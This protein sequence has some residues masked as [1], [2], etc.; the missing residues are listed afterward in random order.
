MRLTKTLRSASK[1]PS[2]IISGGPRA[3]LLRD[4]PPT[5]LQRW[6]VRAC[7]MCLAPMPTIQEIAPTW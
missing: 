2:L 4:Q 7:S 1:Q 6:V 3:E 5:V